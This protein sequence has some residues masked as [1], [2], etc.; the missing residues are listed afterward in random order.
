VG[1][2]TRSLGEQIEL[3]L[4]RLLTLLLGLVDALL[5]VRWGAQALDR[6]EARWQTRL[7]ELDESLAALDREHQRLRSVADALSIHAASLYLG[8]RYLAH[9]ELRFDPAEPR[10]EEVLDAT[11]DVLVKRRL[12]AIEPEDTGEN[13]YVYHL[14]PDWC[15]IRA[16]L[17]AAMNKAET[18]SGIAEWFDEGIAFI[19][20]ALLLEGVNCG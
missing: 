9:G 14:E 2:R 16:R 11:I 6:L 4:L 20:E 19:D 15:A 13:H 10:D 8:R 17:V 1:A 12:A 3:A 18:E 5:G 7:A